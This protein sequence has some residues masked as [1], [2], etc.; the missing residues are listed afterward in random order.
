MARRVVVQVAWY[1]GRPE[2]RHVDVMFE[3]VVAHLFENV[4]SGNIISEFMENMTRLGAVR[5]EMLQANTAAKI[6]ALSLISREATVD[7]ARHG[8]DQSLLVA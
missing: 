4:L 8:A 3:G 5:D 1:P 2:A 7:F 6:Q